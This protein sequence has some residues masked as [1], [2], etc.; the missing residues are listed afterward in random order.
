MSKEYRLGPFTRVLS[1]TEEKKLWDLL[2]KERIVLEMI[3]V[4]EKGIPP[5]NAEN[6]TLELSQIFPD[7][8]KKDRFKQ[9]V[10]YL[11]RQIM[12]NRGYEHYKKGQK[13]Y[14]NDVFVHGSTYRKSIKAND[15]TEPTKRSDIQISRIIRDTGLSRD[16]KEEYDNR[17]QICGDYIQ[18][19]DRKYSEVHHIKPL[20]KPHDGPDKKEN[21]IVLCPNHHAA[22]DL[23]GIALN[24][25]N[26]NITCLDEKDALHGK[27]IFRK[28]HDLGKEYLQYH[29]DKLFM[30]NKRK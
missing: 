15:I 13:T 30:N 2:N 11:V 21:I 18:L 9:L 19:V 14:K 5:V 25:D 10:G 4:S 26:L 20:G 27:K 12:E 1:S 24:P 29:R 6:L 23:G 22:F 28:L 16:L 3:N 8:V 7:Y 17:C